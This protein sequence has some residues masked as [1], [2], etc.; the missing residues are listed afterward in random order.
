MYRVRFHLGRGEHYQ[1]WQVKNMETGHVMYFNPEKV[2]MML[3][4]CRLHNQANATAKIFEGA[5][6]KPCA[7][8]VCEGFNIRPPLSEPQSGFEIA[9][10]PRKA[11]HWALL[12]TGTEDPHCE[13]MDDYK[14]NTIYSVGRQLY[15]HP[16]ECHLV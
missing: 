13:D 16:K 10:N 7:W 3:G 12:Y 2:T 6:K 8:V 1:H 14:Y 9:F 5:H 4:G 15:P 11:K